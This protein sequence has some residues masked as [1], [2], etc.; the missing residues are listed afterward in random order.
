ML[1]GCT[2]TIYLSVSKQPCYLCETWLTALNHTI[3]DPTF[4]V[5]EGHKKVYE[6]WKLPGIIGVDGAGILEVWERFDDL[7]AS[8]R[9][10]DTGDTGDTVIT[11]YLTEDTEPQLQESAMKVIKEHT[12]KLENEWYCS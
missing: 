4:L 7:A 1:D 6:G 12:A 11:L 2:G 9:Y 10:V 3:H 8:V 5:P